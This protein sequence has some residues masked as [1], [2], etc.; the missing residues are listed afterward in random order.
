MNGDT[1]ARSDLVQALTTAGWF[2]FVAWLL[3]LFRQ[4]SRV[5]RVDEQA[6]AG[7][8]E[9]RIEVMSFLVLPQNALLLLPAAALASTA[10]WMSGATESLSLAVQ[11]RVVRWAAIGQIAI[12]IVSIVSIVVNETGS[13]TESE[14]IAL[15]IAGIVMSVAVVKVTAAVERHSPGGARGPV[16]LDDR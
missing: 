3:F 15:R 6:F 16:P 1:T 12:A 9:Q 4:I 10:V 2:A 13:P 14:D 5:V 11:I 7:V 8:G